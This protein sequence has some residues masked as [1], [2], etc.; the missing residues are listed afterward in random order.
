MHTVEML[1]RLLALAG[2]MGYVIRQEWLGG[3]GGGECE[4]GGRRYIFVDL[5][6]SVVEQLEQV[7]SVLRNDPTLPLTRPAPALM[8]M[9]G[10][11][12]AA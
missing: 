11:K 2:Q 12:R 6:L 8:P 7:A 4:F 5:A 1:E 3:S 9:L 10:L